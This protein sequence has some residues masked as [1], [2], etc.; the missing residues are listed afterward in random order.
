MD[1]EI[2]AR[3][4]KC[5]KEPIIKHTIIQRSILVGVFGINAIGRPFW[6]LM[7]AL[8]TIS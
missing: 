1:H 5:M 4:K 2:T 3:R 8:A 6:E 7:Y